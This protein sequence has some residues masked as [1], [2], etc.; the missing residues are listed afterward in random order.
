MFSCCNKSQIAF[1]DFRPVKYIKHSYFW[2]FL[3]Q[4][5]RS[6]HFWSSLSI[7][8]FSQTILSNV[9]HP[10]HSELSDC[11]SRAAALFLFFASLLPVAI[12]LVKAD[13][14]LD[15]ITAVAT[16]EFSLLS[17]QFLAVRQNHLQV[18]IIIQGNGLFTAKNLLSAQ[19][20]IWYND[21]LLLLELC[22]FL[23]LQFH[24]CCAIQQN[25]VYHLIRIMNQRL[26]Q[27]VE[28]FQRL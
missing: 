28:Q 14:R 10:K 8:Q 7:G 13:L 6:M 4:K 1:A 23:R 20:H 25:W 9:F 26:K 3:M 24:K 19:Q 21:G 22:D 12:V 18:C 27:K 5:I 16:T 17:C 11:N 2:Q 15:V